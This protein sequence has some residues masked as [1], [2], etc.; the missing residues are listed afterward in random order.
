MDGGQTLGDR[1][2]ERDVGPAAC[3]P[4]RG[5][6]RTMA[7]GREEAGLQDEACGMLFQASPQVQ[8]G[9]V[10]EELCPCPGDTAEGS[11]RPGEPSPTVSLWVTG[12][13]SQRLLALLG[14]CLQYRLHLS[15][16]PQGV[17]RAL[18]A[19]IATRYEPPD[20]RSAMGARCYSLHFH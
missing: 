12:E 4:L 5:H 7:S 1:R 3:C 16:H 2:G 9:R 6:H 18:L 19:P 17:L 20:I 13:W 8:E 14:V 10:Q 15:S 11:S